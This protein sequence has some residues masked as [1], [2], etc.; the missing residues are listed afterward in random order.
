MFS[1]NPART[2]TAATG[3]RAPAWL[4]TWRFPLLLIATLVLMAAAQE[5]TVVLAGLSILDFLVGVAAGAVVLFCYVRLSKFVE[6]RRSVTELPRE[7]ARSG[8]LVGTA[9]GG[10][11]FLLT[12]LIILVFGGW[13]VTG[14]DSGKFLGT[15][16]IMACTAVTEEVVFRGVVFRIAEERFG[17][18]IALAISAVLFG[19]IHLGG[20]SETSAGAE[21]WGVCAII[22]QGGLLLGAGYMATRTLWVPIGLHFAWN[23]FEAGF[24]TA[25]SGKTSEFGSL[26]QTTLTGSPV[27]TGGSF[28]PEAGVAAIFSCLLAAGLMI[29][30]GVRRGN[31]VRRGQTREPRATLA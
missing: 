25:V 8:L 1:R 15:I 26:I 31:I 22:L 19:V 9:L 7:K 13:Q 24:G 4:R 14:G 30:Y 2:E 17:T 18:W 11:A 28:G 5:L 21:L 3:R 16:G 12:M 6:G 23:T 10:G 29:A 20:I 27:V